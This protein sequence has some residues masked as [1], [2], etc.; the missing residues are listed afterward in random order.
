M[1]VLLLWVAV[2]APVQ[3]V[4]VHRDRVEPHW[5]ADGDRFWYRVDT[6]AGDEFV[7]IDAVAGT[8]KAAFDAERTAADLKRATG[9]D[10]AKVDGLNWLP[11]G[12][13]TL[14]SGRTWYRSGDDGLTPVGPAE[15]T[16]LRPE[17][18]LPSGERPV[19]R[20]GGGETELVFDNRTRKTLELYWRDNE[21]RRQ[22]YGRIEPGKSRRQHTFAGHV[23]EVADATGEPLAYFRAVADVATAEITDDLPEPQP[24]TARRRPSGRRAPDG[25]GRVGIEDHNVVV[26]DG[27]DT[28]RITTDGSAER[29]Y[30]MPAWSP[31]GRRLVAWRVKPEPA[32]PVYRIES[33]PKGGGRAVLHS[34]PYLLPGD[35]MPEYRLR[36]F[37]AKTG[38]PIDCGADVIDFGRPRIRWRADG[39]RLTYQHVDR[40]H[41]R[42]RLVEVDTEAGAV[43]NIVDERSDTFLWTAH[44]EQRGVPL[45]TWVGDDEIVYASERSGWRHLY[46]IDVD[47]D[48]TPRPITAGEWVVR[49]ID[50]IDEEARQLWLAASGRNA[51]EDP[52]H[53]HHY[54]IGLDGD[55][56]V[57]LTAGDGMHSL[58]HSP[59]G[60]FLIDRFSRIDLPP[61]HVLRTADGET[62]C[63]LE[64]AEVTGDWQ[65]PQVFHAEGRDGK[66]GIWGIVLRPTGTP[67][68]AGWPVIE[69]IY[70]GPHGAHVP[71]EFSTYRRH[72]DLTEAGFVVVQIDGMGTAHRSKAF[73]DVCWHDLKDAGFPDRIAWIEA[74]AAED[75]RIDASRVGVFGTSAGGQNAAGA[76][77]FHGD[78]YSAAVANCGCHDNSMDKAS[79]NEQWMGYPVGPQYAASSNIE[80]AGNLAGAL[81]LVV[82]EL[83]TNVPP[84]S[85]LRL[86]AALI[87]AG[88]DFELIHVPGGRHGAGGPYARRRLRAFFVDHLKP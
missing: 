20:G 39:R 52:Y 61:V 60:R 9:S 83:D 1:S 8:R 51:G 11:D 67:P 87:A 77:L 38:S 64:A 84:E 70:A 73:H 45:V 15:A 22:S 18:L 25:A 13:L 48:A 43:R 41:Q 55:N 31:D 17:T 58:R 49:G 81:Q 4:Q 79:W 36:I 23:W 3:N 74:L 82:G 47:G 35:A 26:R 59:D 75:Q 14:R 80:F 27:D 29:P 37:D 76:L 10:D 28:R 69:A 56:L 57:A 33:A 44:A 71:K 42:L 21:G 85:T 72:R 63:E 34:S 50:R 2:L 86:G 78:F 16:A 40:G 7:V 19:S 12:G 24:P 66:T 30:A 6:A 5:S 65:P 46:L 54:R 32:K 68:A 62:V 53:V 88:K